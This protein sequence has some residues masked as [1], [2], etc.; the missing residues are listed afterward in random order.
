V[1]FQQIAGE[2]QGTRVYINVY[3]MPIAQPGFISVNVWV[4][5]DNQRVTDVFSYRIKIEHSKEP[6]RSEAGALAPALTQ[7]KPQ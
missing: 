2:G 4:E 6:I 3:G 7:T 5:H 1:T